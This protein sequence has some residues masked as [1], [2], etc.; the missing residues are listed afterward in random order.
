MKMLK[1][2]A[3]GATLLASTLSFNTVAHAQGADSTNN[4][5]NVAQPK[6]QAKADPLT[7]TQKSAVLGLIEQ[8]DL[9]V[10]KVFKAIK[11]AS[12]NR[13]NSL[14]ALSK[15]ECAKL[16]KFLEGKVA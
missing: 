3:L 11:W 16:I 6:P 2:A 8:A 4:H 13:T 10:D 12:G 5:G 14:N 7:G 15:V 9:E 1:I